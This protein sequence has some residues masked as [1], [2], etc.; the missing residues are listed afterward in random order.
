[1]ASFQISDPS[2]KLILTDATEA[3]RPVAKGSVTFVVEN[4]TGLNRTAS[5]DLQPQDAAD[6]AIYRIGGS[7]PTNPT[8]RS[9]DFTPH[10]IQNVEVTVK[11]PRGATTKS[12]SFRLRAALEDDPDNDAIDSRPV[13]FDISAAPPPPPPAKAAFPW[14]AVGVGVVLVA[15]IGG[16]AWYVLHRHSGKTKVTPDMI[17][18]LVGK[19]VKVAEETILSWNYS[20]ALQNQPGPANPGVIATVALDPQSSS[21]VVLTYD[22]GVAIPNLIGQAPTKIGDVFVPLAGKATAAV[23][24]TRDDPN[25]CW[26]TISGQRP[27]SPSGTYKTGQSFFFVVTNGTKTVGCIHIVPLGPH[28]LDVLKSKNILVPNH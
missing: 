14:W 21:Q 27:L 28:W 16:G 9:L 10:Q 19:P 1:M 2:T 15:L 25:S 8:I 5:F 12:A 24:S 13:A 17:A 23:E 4:L 6:A 20:Y 3:G 7:T 18:G 11:A 26:D 22:E